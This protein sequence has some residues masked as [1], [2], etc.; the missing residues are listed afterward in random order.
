M[1][2]KLEQGRESAFLSKE[3]ATAAFDAP[4]KAT[5]ADLKWKGPDRAKVEALFDRLGMAGLRGRVLDL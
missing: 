5:L 2:V 3:L 4:A 1:A